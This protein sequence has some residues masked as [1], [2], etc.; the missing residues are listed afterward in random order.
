MVNELED[1][2]R[3]AVHAHRAP[4]VVQGQH[5]AALAAEVASTSTEQ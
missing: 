1:V 5:L 2:S 3:L 4:P